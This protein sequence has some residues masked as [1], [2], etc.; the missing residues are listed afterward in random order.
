MTRPHAA[1][2]RHADGAG[3]D[4][5]R[6]ITSYYTAKRMMHALQVTLQRHEATFR[7]LDSDVQRGCSRTCARSV[8]RRRRA[9]RGVG[10]IIR[11][12]VEDG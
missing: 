3:G 9:A 2:F 8:P 10:R 1:A 6:I 4:P 12:L 11:L 5:Q 7:V